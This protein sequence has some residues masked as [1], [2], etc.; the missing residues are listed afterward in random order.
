[1]TKTKKLRAAV[2]GCG[3]VART[4]HLPEYVNCKDTE[5]VAY[6]DID[7]QSVAETVERY[8]KRP[9]YKSYKELLAKESPDCVSVCLPNYLHCEVAVAALE[10]G[11]SVLVEKPMAL[12][13]PE[14]DR[15]IETA[16]R[17]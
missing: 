16:K 15:M 4:L 1:M 17:K 9:V 8:G 11:A 13:L 14:A 2:I 5:L 10:A 12:T 6:C 3:K 7:P